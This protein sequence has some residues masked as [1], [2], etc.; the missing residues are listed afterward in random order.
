MGTKQPI[1]FSLTCHTAHCI[2]LVMGHGK[3]LRD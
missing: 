3:R 1:V 2:N